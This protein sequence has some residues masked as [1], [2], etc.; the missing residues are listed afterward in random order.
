MLSFQVE[1]EKKKYNS[2]SMS[3]LI[4][5]CPLKVGLDILA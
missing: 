1:G 4:A 3:L 2:K 5:T